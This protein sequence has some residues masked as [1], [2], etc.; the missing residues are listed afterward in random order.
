MVT[1]ASDPQD[2][3][4]AI[5]LARQA[6]HPRVRATAGIHPH[7]ADRCGADQLDRIRELAR[8]EWV[9]AIGET[10]LDYH[11]QNAPREVQRNAFRSQLDL[12]SE[13]G[14]PVVVHSREADEDMAGIIDEYAGRVAGVLHC[15]TGS[16]ELAEAGLTAGWHISFSGIITFSSFDD[17]EIVRRVPE[18][19]LLIETDSPYLAPVPR[20]GRRNEPANVAHVARR[21]AEIRDV[22]A[23]SVAQITYRNACRF[24]HLEND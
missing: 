1:I 10:G 14:L 4:R 6:G 15:F 3:S 24:Y 16:H 18:D 2:A 5:I 20:R 12:A 7:V 11:Y 19:R 8:S 23:E 9:V 17:P 22:P 13:L 21:V